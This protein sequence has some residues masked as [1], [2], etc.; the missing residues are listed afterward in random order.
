MVIHAVPTA[1]GAL[2]YLIE[3][4][5]TTVLGLKCLVIGY[6]RVSISLAKI[7]RALDADVTVCARQEAQLVRAWAAGYKTVHLS[8]LGDVIGDFDFVVSGASSP[9]LDR[10]LI[11]RTRP[12]ALI[13]ELAAPPGSI[14]LAAAEQLKRRTVWPR[15]QAS[16]APRTVGYHEWLYM[17]RFM[18]NPA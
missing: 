5:D 3:L 7:L 12:D 4:T 6:G 2:K 18:T 11:A 13:M 10:D 9:V 16:T 15:G 17:L 14:D 1:E 8:G